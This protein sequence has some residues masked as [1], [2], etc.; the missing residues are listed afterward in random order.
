VPKRSGSPIKSSILRSKTPLLFSDVWL[1][2]HLLFE[3]L[4][5]SLQGFSN[6]KKCLE[7]NQ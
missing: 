2:L 1:V 6:F 5:A 7:E 4:E 3:C